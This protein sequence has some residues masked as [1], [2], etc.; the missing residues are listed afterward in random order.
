[1]MSSRFALFPTVIFILS[2]GCPVLGQA[3]AE[4]LSLTLEEAVTLAMER[5]PVILT[6]RARTDIL[7]GQIK[8]VKSQAYPSINLNSTGVRWRDPAFLNSSSFDDIPAEFRDAMVPKGA[9]L[10]DYNVSVAQP[11]YT[12][13]KVGTALQLAKLEREGVG[14]DVTKIEQDIR[15][16]VVR[17]FYGVLLSK[18]HLEI[19][20]DTITQRERHLEMARTRFRGG[21][22]TEVDVLRSEVSVAN[23]KP[24][25]LRAENGVRYARSV[26][27]NLMA[28]PTDF[29]TD[30]IVELIYIDA[31]ES[32]IQ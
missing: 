6:A 21:V 26:L 23:A 18:K 17:A 19:A 27:N 22:A 24:D 12:A 9:N 20:Q 28:R 14:I 1:M 13:G 30:V 8:Q 11:L 2:L 29:P 25:L 10:F 31:A 4:K 7:E 32:G 16:Q 3:S 5:N 15:V